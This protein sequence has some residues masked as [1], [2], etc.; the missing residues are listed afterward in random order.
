VAT[1]GQIE[2]F[3]FSGAPRESAMDWD[4]VGLLV[5]DPHQA[6]S[7]VLVALDV[8]EAVADEAAALDAQLIVSHHPVMNCT[9][10]PVQS[11]REDQAQGRLLRGL[12]RRNLAVI[13]MHTNLDLASGGVND[14]LAEALKLVDPGPLGS[15]GLG[16]VGTLR[17]SPVSLSDFIRM[18]SRALHCQGVRYADAGVPVHRVAVGGGACGEYMDQAIAQGCD[19][20]VTADLKYHDFLNACS[21]GLNLID[22]GHFPTEDPICRVLAEKLERVFPDLT[23]KK[24]DSHREVIQYYV[25]GE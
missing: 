14:V 10:L 1:A 25:E 20:F 8:T 12:V 3:L 18:I 23:V 11:L 21:R 24:S 4:N 19:T 2:Q 16:R 13:C 15:D 22:A 9:W 5:G 6:V 7:R 17:E